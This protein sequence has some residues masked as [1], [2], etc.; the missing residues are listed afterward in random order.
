M[1]QHLWARLTGV[2][3]CLQGNSSRTRVPSKRMWTQFN[4]GWSNREK[5]EAPGWSHYRPCTVLAAHI[6]P[7]C[8]S[9]ESCS[10]TLAHT[11]DFWPQERHR[12]CCFPSQGV[13]L[14]VCRQCGGL[15]STLKPHGSVCLSWRPARCMAA[16]RRGK[17]FQW[18]CSNSE[19]GLFFLF[20]NPYGRVKTDLKGL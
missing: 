1:N 5:N 6:S 14:D 9:S 20:T 13:L 12:R 16:A 19:V 2:R 18:V 11:W 4:P 15:R 10:R 7:P 8:V 17:N 3:L